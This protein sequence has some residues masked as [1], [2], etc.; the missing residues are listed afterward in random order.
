MQNVAQDITLQISPP[1][2]A[3]SNPVET[4]M[5]SLGKAM[6]IG[7]HNEK[8]SLENE[9]LRNFFKKYRQTPHPATGLPPAADRHVWTSQQ[10]RDA[11][12]EDIIIAR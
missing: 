5:R 7:R 11:T 1:L 3:A 10:E 9:S 2:H 12:E 4:F 6:K 8:T